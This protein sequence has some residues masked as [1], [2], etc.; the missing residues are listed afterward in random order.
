MIDELH[1]TWCRAVAHAACCGPS[2][3]ECIANRIA[4]RVRNLPAD[5]ATT[6]RDYGRGYAQACRDV[7]EL[8]EGSA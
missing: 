5:G 1:E 8:L 7:I 2:S 6:S 4:N 3:C